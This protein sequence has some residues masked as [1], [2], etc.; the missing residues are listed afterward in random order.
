M[1]RVT[2]ERSRRFGRR[3]AR[4]R[5]RW[6]RRS[7]A[8]SLRAC[9]P[10][11]LELEQPR[12]APSDAGS[13][14]D[15][16][17]TPTRT[18]ATSHRR[19]T[20]G[21][22]LQAVPVRRPADPGAGRDLRHHLG[23]IERAHRLPFPP[24]NFGGRHVHVRRLG[25]RDRRVHRHRRQDHALVRTPTRAPTNQSAPRRRRSRTSTARSSSTCTRAGRIVGQGG[26]PEQATPIGVITN[27]ND[28]GGAASTRRRPTASASA[29]S[30]RAVAGTRARSPATT[31]TT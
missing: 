14:V 30:P 12:D 4:H 28:N 17:T 18:A 5:R 7:A 23:R 29:P 21:S 24:D 25:V 10:G 6:P 19:T 13:T 11:V 15:A 26:Y 20:P 16:G 3:G 22:T 9:R 31:R 27:Q 2:D 8:R 1:K